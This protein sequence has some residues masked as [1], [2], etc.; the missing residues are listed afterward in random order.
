MKVQNTSKIKWG[1]MI[2]KKFKR[3]YGETLSNPVL[4]ELPCGLEWKVELSDD[5][6]CFDKGWAEFADYYALE[7]GHMLVFR[8]KGNS[9]FHVFI[10]DKSTSEIDYPTNSTRFRKPNIEEEIQEDDFVEI[11]DDFSPCPK[12][13]EK[14]P[15]P[16]SRPQKRMKTTP[17]GKP[18]NKLKP[19]ISRRM[20]AHEKAKALK[21]ASG[22]SSEN[23]FFVV[24]LPPSSVLYKIYPLTL[25]EDNMDDVILKVSDGRTWSVKCSLKMYGGRKTI[26][27]LCCGWE[28]FVQ[29]N[30][31]EVGDVCVFVLT[32]SSKASFEVVIFRENGIENL[33]VSPAGALKPEVNMRQPN[34]S[35]ANTKAK[36]LGKVINFQSENP[37]FTIALGRSYVA[38]TSFLFIPNKFARTYIKK[39]EGDGTLSVSDVKS[40]PVQYK[41]RRV[42]D[43]SQVAE[44]RFGWTSFA[45]DNGL[46]VGDICTF[47]LTNADEISFKVHINR[48]A[49][50]APRLSVP[51]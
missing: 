20:T 27:K 51:Q 30:D 4:L 42:R 36:A 23:P 28:T 8:Y 13:R 22:F 26:A 16:C 25:R 15:L 45:R 38:R 37:F 31:L 10:F 47:E 46:S 21:K 41:V 44:L 39:S 3:K 5:K 43:R 34:K 33:P 29:D 17:S 11:L 49:V 12:S 50:N 32:R 9:Q 1:S 6:V 14:S 2:P 7:F 18:Q 19:G 48:V 35:T 24:V 40:W